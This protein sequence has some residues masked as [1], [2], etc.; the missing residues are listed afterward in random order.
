MP[1]FP[2]LPAPL[3]D[4]VV[5][6]R[7]ASDWDIPDILIAHQDDAQLHRRL[8]L[9][10]PPSGAELGRRS[11]REPAERAAGTGLRLTIV[12]PGERTGRGQLEVYDVRWEA[13]QARIGIWVAP[14]RRGRGLASQALRL[15]ASWLS[16]ACGLE[17]LTL[18]TTPDNLAMIGAA[19]GAGF[20]EAAQAPDGLSLTLSRPLPGPPTA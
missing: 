20:T 12:E 6:L 9:E 3:S 11:E 16:E 15:A 17:H 10:R 19:R 1:S 7:L 14:S 4:G 8:G 13:G 5:E 2:N 18:T